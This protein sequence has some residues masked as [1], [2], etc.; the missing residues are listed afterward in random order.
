MNE[1]KWETKWWHYKNA[2]IFKHACIVITLTVASLLISQALGS[3]E[4]VSR[5]GGI[6]TIFGASLMVR[7]LRR[8]GPY[9][10]NK[11]KQ[12]AVINGNQ[13]NMAYIHEQ[14]SDITDNHAEYIGFVIVIIGTM[15]WCYG[16]YFLELFFPF[17]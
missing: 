1:I 11:K 7:R 9:G 6:I 17:N 13:L 2:G 15:L 10:A 4:H 8:L 12:P 3:W 5:I 16:D 14:V